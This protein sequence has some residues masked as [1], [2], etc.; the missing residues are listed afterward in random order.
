MNI[1]QMD[2]KDIDIDF[3]NAKLAYT[4]IESLLSH[5]ESVHD[6]L[7]LMSHALDQDVAKALTNTNEWQTYIESK[8]NLENTKLQI[9]KFTE[10]LEK[11][12]SEEG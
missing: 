5:N 8:R 9:E 7:A 12:E 11:L 2:M 4:I 1:A 3:P 10:E 6:L